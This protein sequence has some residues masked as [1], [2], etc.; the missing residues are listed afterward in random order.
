MD[1]INVYLEFFEQVIQGINV[2]SVYDVITKDKQLTIG[3]LSLELGQD[4]PD[5]VFSPKNLNASSGTFSEKQRNKRTAKTSIFPMDSGAKVN[6]NSQGTKQPPATLNNVATS[7]PKP[8]MDSFI[9]VSQNLTTG[10]KTFQCTFCGVSMGS[11][12]NMKRHVETTHIPSATV[13]KCQTCGATAKEKSNM[14]KHYMNKHKMPEAAAR[15]ML[16]G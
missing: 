12:G 8:S 5:P 14:K 10:E 11:K 4:S 2:P 1:S 15:G 16:L 9:S 13:Y 7:V 3:R 6:K